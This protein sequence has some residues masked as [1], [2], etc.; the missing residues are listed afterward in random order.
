MTRTSQN[1]KLFGKSYKRQKL[2][3][4]RLKNFSVTTVWH[5]SRLQIIL[6]TQLQFLDL[7]LSSI[8]LLK[9]QRAFR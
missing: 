9:N 1:R 4:K 7:S 2:I 8:S 5:Q 3:R 6:L